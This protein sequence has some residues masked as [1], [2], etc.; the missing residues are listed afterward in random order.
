[1]TLLDPQVT[2]VKLQ[3]ELDLWD[4]NY[5]SYSRRGWIMLAREQLSVEVGFLAR[6][7]VGEQTITAMP[8]CV[9]IDFTNYDLWAP[10]V[11]FVDP[12]T[13]EFAAPAVQGLM[14]AEAGAQNVLVAGHPQTGRPFFC[15]PGIREYHEHPQHTGDPWL[16]HRAG[17]EGSLATICDRV[18]RAMARTLLG[19]HVQVQTL[20]GQ[21]QFQ[22]RLASA[23]GEVAPAMWRQA[24]AN[25]QAQA[26]ASDG[27]PRAQGVSAQMLAALGVIKPA[28]AEA[29]GGN[30]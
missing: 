15:V 8:A 27:A 12:F 2:Q 16:L 13:R 26:A 9:R 14:E 11:E 3:R 25:Q 18:W 6:L 21:I 10:S 20:P 1:V 17:G 24:E 19:I 4:E 29:P 30:P 5:E 23:P 28:G 22:L 7:P